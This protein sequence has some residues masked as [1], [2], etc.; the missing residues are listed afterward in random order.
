MLDWLLGPDASYASSSWCLC[1]CTAVKRLIDCDTDK[2]G[3]EDGQHVPVLRIVNETHN[4]GRAT[5]NATV[6]KDKLHKHKRSYV[7]K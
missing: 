2:N 6:E 5:A 1:A 7:I 3:D 4:T